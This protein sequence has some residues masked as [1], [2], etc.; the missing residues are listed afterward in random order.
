MMHGRDDVNCC[1]L[2]VCTGSGARQAG[3]P[4]APPTFAELTDRVQQQE[5]EALA[6]GGQW[7]LCLMAADPGKRAV[8]PVCCMRLRGPQCSQSGSPAALHPCRP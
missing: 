3:S 7:Q 8:C 5:E 2:G 1:D 6:G 4:R